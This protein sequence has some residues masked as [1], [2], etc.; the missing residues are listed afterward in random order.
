M[1]RISVAACSSSSFLLLLLLLASEV[2]MLNC[3]KEDCHLR[4]IIHLLKHP[5]CIPKPIPSFACTGKCSSYVQVCRS[6]FAFSCSSSPSSLFLHRKEEELCV[7][8]LALQI[9]QCMHWRHVPLCC[10]SNDI[11]FPSIRLL[12]LL[13]YCHCPRSY[14]AAILFR[15]SF[16]GTMTNAIQSS[17]T[18]SLTFSMSSKLSLRLLSKVSG[19]KF[20]QVERSCMCCQ[21][22]GEREATI[23]IFCPKQTPRFRKVSSTLF[24]RP[25]NWVLNTLLL[26]L[27]SLLFSLQIVTRAPVECMCRPCTGID[28]DS[29]QPQEI[30]NL[31]NTGDDDVPAPWLHSYIYLARFRL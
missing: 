13:F 15:P 29:L 19:S 10:K 4:P 1:Q 18:F 27:L 12:L 31:V 17:L 21:E 2:P 25:F 23:G 9:N 3:V 7:P 24:I 6:I 22:M 14:L 11:L 16:T 5:G 28:E 26:L 8:R 20:W 30:L